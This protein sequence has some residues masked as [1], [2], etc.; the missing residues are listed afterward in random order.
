MSE[1]TRTQYPQNE[2]HS[3]RSE[4]P[5]TTRRNVA[6]YLLGISGTV[7]L[8]TYA[9]EYL[10][11]VYS[12]GSSAGSGQPFVNGTLLVDQNGKKF[13]VDSLSPDGSDEA[14]AFPEK[15]G[16]GALVEKNAA[17]ILVR[18][19]ESEYKPPTNVSGT[20]KGYVAYSKVCTHEGCLISERQ[21]QNFL[22]P[23]HSSVY[24]PLEGAKV[25]G[26]PAPRP[27]PQLPLGIAKSGNLLLATGPF[28]GP[29]GP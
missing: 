26:G 7:A 13:T 4:L 8:G 21:G 23:C 10:A 28:D 5:V 2:Q 14:T 22:C 25:V 1:K 17:T 19:K 27:V 11:G 16:G 20:V 9:I 12:G 18:F 6:K 3:N 24:D 29:I 15:K